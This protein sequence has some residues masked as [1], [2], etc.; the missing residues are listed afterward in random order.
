LRRT[1]PNP[2]P[3]LAPT[4]T[5]PLP[6]TST[7]PLTFT[8]PLALPLALPLTLTLPLTRSDAETTRTQMIRRP[9]GASRGYSTTSSSATTMRLPSWAG[10]VRPSKYSHSKCSHSK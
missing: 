3:D 10:T 6:L 1:Y 9:I 2:H 7:L 5:L 8:L 4:L